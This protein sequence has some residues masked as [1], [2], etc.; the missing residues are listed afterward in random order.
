MKIGSLSSIG[1]DISKVLPWLKLAYIP[2]ISPASFFELIR[3]FGSSQAALDNL[4]SMTRFIERKKKLVIPSDERI[5]KEIEEVANFGAKIV[6]A[7]EPNYPREL[8][9][10]PDAPPVLIV[11]GDDRLLTAPK[12]IAIVGSRNASVN[13]MK[14]AR[15]IASEISDAGY[16]VVSGLALGIDSAAHEGALK[17]GTIG[18]IAGD[19][20]T[21]YPAKN[22]RL[23]ERMY[24]SGLVVT[25]WALNT[26]LAPGLLAIRNRI[27]SGLCAGVVVV[28]AAK[29][30]GTL[31]TAR[32]AAEQGREVLAVPGSPFDLR[33]SGTNYLIKSGASLVESAADI[34]SEIESVRC[35][36]LSFKEKSFAFKDGGEESKFNKGIPSDIELE[37]Y[38]KR[39]LELIPYS[40]VSI[41]DI[42]GYVDA[43]ISIVNYIIVELELAG[44]VFRVYSNGVVRIGEGV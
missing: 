29:K 11:K 6:C 15:N 10:I 20:K 30:S 12:K 13:G 23:F 43:D 4:D 33:S 34:I 1:S 44:K 32:F 36:L 28:E 18:V 24:S 41:S 9:K 39:I 19:I 8:A 40:V 31:I 2:E 3:V 42:A 5:Y 14:I 16:I 17:N 7:F 27:I 38:R 25:E 35:D 26:N 37:R 21:V 22:A